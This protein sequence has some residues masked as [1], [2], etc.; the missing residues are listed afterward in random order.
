MWLYMWDNDPG[1]VNYCHDP[2]IFVMIRGS[3]YISVCY[4]CIISIILVLSLSLYFHL[5]FLSSHLFII[6]A[7]FHSAFPFVI[8]VCI[9]L[10]SPRSLCVY[11]AP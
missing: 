3:I 6:Y 10:E 7:Y 8:C 11:I 4:F 5:C 2:R 9:P 1:A